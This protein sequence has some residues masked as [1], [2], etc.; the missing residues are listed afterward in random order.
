VVRKAL[1]PDDDLW[2]T[3]TLDKCDRDIAALIDTRFTPLIEAAEAVLRSG[4]VVTDSHG[5]YVLGV[6]V[7][8]AAAMKAAIA[9]AKGAK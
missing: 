6:C 7:D 9:N 2:G 4:E 1:D 3:M 5:M 8:A